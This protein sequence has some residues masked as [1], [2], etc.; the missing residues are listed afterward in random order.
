MSLN[1][2]ADSEVELRRVGTVNAPVAVGSRDPVYNFLCCW[3]TEVGHKWRYNDVSKV[4]KSIK[5]HI[6]KPLWSLFSQ[7]ANCRPN[8]SAAVVS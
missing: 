6:V 5:I 7:S 2:F 8:L 1:K 4:I 3:A